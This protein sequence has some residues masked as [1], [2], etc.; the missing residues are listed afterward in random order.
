MA[1]APP[2]FPAAQF[3]QMDE[4]KTRAKAAGVQI[5]DLSIGTPDILPP[6]EALDALQVIPRLL[7]LARRRPAHMQ[8]P[9]ALASAATARRRHLPRRPLSATRSPT[10]TA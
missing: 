3:L 5:T 2:P 1:P 9:R 7:P 4:A 8:S 10:S 6:P